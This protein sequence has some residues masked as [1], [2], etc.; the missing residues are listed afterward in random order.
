MS[1]KLQ[2]TKSIYKD[3]LHLKKFFSYCAKNTELSNRLERDL[4]YSF[5]KLFSVQYNIVDYM[6][7]FEQ[8]SRTYFSFL[9]KT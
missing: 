5:N 7:N 3:Q 2:D 6:Y 1:A 9:T 8:L 4:I